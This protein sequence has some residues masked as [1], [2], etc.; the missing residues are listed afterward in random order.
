VAG[1]A[2]AGEAV[3]LTRSVDASAQ[4]EIENI[5]GSVTVKGWNQAQ[6]K[7]TGTLGD[8]VEELKVSGDENHLQIEVEVPDSHGFGKRDVESHLEVWVPEGC[9]LHVETISARIEVSDVNG[10]AALESVSGGVDLTGQPQQVDVET[11]SGSIEIEGSQTEISAES[12]SG[13]VTLSGVVRSVEV[14]TVS[15]RIEVVAGEIDAADFESVSGSITFSG[16]LTSNAELDIEA[17]SGSVDL[18]LPVGTAASFEVSTFSGG[19]RNG[20]SDRQAERTSRYT[21]GR[22]LEFSTGS[23]GAE[24]SIETFSGS[25]N[26]HPR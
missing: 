11:V 1:I 7:V 3:D 9:R 17:H 15:G 6:V 20:F 2:L 12:V 25:V 23:G 18:A 4:I 19:I 8:D 5:S 26:L 16:S 21:P 10:T 14:E 13:S 24:I 22:Y